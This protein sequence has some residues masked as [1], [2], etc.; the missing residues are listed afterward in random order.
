MGC[1][2]PWGRIL[3]Y[4]TCGGGIIGGRGWVVKWAGSRWP[5]FDPQIAQILQGLSHH[6]SKLRIVRF[7]EMKD[8]PLLLPDGRV[9]AGERSSKMARSS[10]RIRRSLAA[11]PA[12]SVYFADAAFR[13]RIVQLSPGA[14]EVTLCAR[15]LMRA[16][17]GGGCA[18]IQ[19]GG[20]P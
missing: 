9:S 14:R 13:A 17:A 11:R 5:G 18:I 15:T 19:T 8:S 16:I 12:G 6:L 4:G 20:N 10:H 3:G 7:A 1:W 2:R